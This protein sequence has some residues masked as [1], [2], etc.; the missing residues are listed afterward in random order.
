MNSDNGKIEKQ[1]SKM[2]AF[3]VFTIG[4]VLGLLRYATM[5]SSGVLL[6]LSIA[7]P[8]LSVASGFALGILLIYRFKYLP[9]LG[10]TIVVIPGLALCSIGSLSVIAFA[11]MPPIVAI[12]LFEMYKRNAKRTTVVGGSALACSVAYLLYIALTLSIYASS[13]G[14]TLY[15]ALDI[16]VNTTSETVRGVLLSP[17]MQ[18]YIESVGADL[19]IEEFASSG[20]RMAANM[21]RSMIMLS[22]GIIGAVYFVS[23]YI[24]SIPLKRIL[25]NSSDTADEKPITILSTKDFEIRVQKQ[26][27][28]Y[29][30]EFTATGVTRTVFVVAMLVSAFATGFE[31]SEMIY[32]TATNF[33]LSFMPLFF[34]IGVKMIYQYI[35]PFL[36]GGTIP[37]MIVACLFFNPQMIAMFVAGFGAVSRSVENQNNRHTL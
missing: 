22:P 20:A 37:A 14:M 35:K 9:I 19:T 4:V 21:A 17:E 34:I 15:Q 12:V 27:V 1:Q 2:F 10:M 23:A 28:G 30:P 16:I 31:S 7:E 25:P 8:I 36:K 18:S 5:L 3:I 6:L 24:V 11:I 13:E 29:N 32:Y 26:K 33:V